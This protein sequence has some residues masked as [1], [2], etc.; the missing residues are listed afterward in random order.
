MRGTWMF[1]LLVG[2]LVVA[3]MASYADY[4]RMG[5]KYTLSLTKDYTPSMW[6]QEGGYL[7]KTKHKLLFGGT[8][9]LFGWLELYNEPREAVRENRG[10]FHGVKHGVVN[11]LGDTVGG[12][13]NLVTFPITALDVPLPEGGTDL[14]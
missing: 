1:A 6:T 3:P 13:I 7:P 4:S 10:F 5:A 2:L 11:M 12:A 9:I 8:N 14:L